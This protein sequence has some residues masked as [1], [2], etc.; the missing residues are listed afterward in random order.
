MIYEAEQGNAT[1]ALCGDIMPS[2]RLAVFREPEFLALREILRDADARF[3]NLESL[4]VRYGEGTPAIRT[5]THMVTE[6]TLLDD[7][8]WFG[9]NMLSCA[10]SHS[11]NF[12]E[13]GL[14]L[15]NQYLDQAGIVHAGTGGNLRQASSPAYL[16]TPNG[17]IALIAAT[18]HLPSEQNRAANQRVDF[19]GKPGVNPL[20]FETTFVIDREAFTALRRL[21]ASLG[22]DRQRQRVADHGFHTDAEIGA[23]TEAEYKFRGDRYQLGQAFE[24]KTSCNEDDLQENLRQIREARRQADWVI[25][26][27]HNQDLIGR[28]WLTAQKRTEITVQPDFVRDFARRCIEEGADVFAGHGPHILMGIEIY[29]EKPI[30]YSL[31]NLIMQNETLR[32]VPGYPFDRFGLDPRSTPSDFFDSRT[33]GGKKGHPASAEFWQSM[34]AVC[35]FERRKLTSIELHPVD[36]GHGLP[37]PQR[38]RPILA[39]KQLAATILERV[40]A[41][42]ETFGTHVE[43][44][45]ARGLI[46]IR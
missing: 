41:M 42:S 36:L 32:R 23:A 3:A 39:D 10:N 8:K 37:R 24:I 31:G 46:N 13:T 4:V 16:D 7:L 38:G 25:F 15:Q 1:I 27:L 12:G 43:Q 5:G 14:L 19:P 30:F 20:G 28:S 40:A 17:R 9:F 21:G 35:R 44:R 18:S 26:S 22:F 33:A 29:R 11:L 2:R 45:N 34:V 6:P